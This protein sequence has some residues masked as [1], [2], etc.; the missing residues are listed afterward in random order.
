MG[1]SKPWLGRC[2]GW[3]VILWGRV[4]RRGFHA[5]IVA[6]IVAVAAVLF[7]L[8]AVGLSS[9]RAPGSVALE[10]QGL[11]NFVSPWSQYENGRYRQVTGTFAVFR[12]QN[13]SGKRIIY[14]ADTVDVQ[15]PSGW[16]TQQILPS[17]PTNWYYFGMILSAAAERRF[18]VPPP[19]T[20]EPWR[21][22]L[23]CCEKA[24]GV[25]GLKRTAIDSWHNL[26]GGR[27]EWFT[28]PTFQI[29]S[30]AVSP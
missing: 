8:L 27:S 18:L 9:R 19:S 2:A 26:R 7:A 10:Y 5:A 14:R 6:G 3:R 21:I 4:C 1:M 24:G 20:N 15:T 30:P 17:A 29:A 23:T 12:L 11:T 13:H 28:G 22:R 16:T 25:E